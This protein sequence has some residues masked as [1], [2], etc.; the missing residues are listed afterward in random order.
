MK[1]LVASAIALCAMS[2]ASAQDGLRLPEGHRAYTIRTAKSDLSDF[3]LPGK[4]VDVIQKE[5]K[6]VMLVK[7]VLVVA[8]DEVQGSD[9]T[10]TIAVRPEDANRL[11]IAKGKLSVRLRARK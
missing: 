8:V 10:V 2:I 7:D 1:A 5:P 4:R 3:V 6:E 9:P 11:A